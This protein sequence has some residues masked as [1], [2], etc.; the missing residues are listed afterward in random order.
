MRILKVLIAS[1]AF[2]ISCICSAQEL[3]VL[4][5]E[6]D[7]TDLTAQQRNRRDA[8]GNIC[9]LLRVLILDSGTK[10]AGELAYATE[11]LR[12]EY[13]VWLN[14]GAESIYIKTS[15]GRILSVDFSELGETKLMPGLVYLLRVDN[16]LH[17]DNVAK[18]NF[19]SLKV[20]PEDAV[21]KINGEKQDYRYGCVSLYLPYGSYEYEISK[22]G[23]ETVSGNFSVSTE[24]YTKH[25]R[26]TKAEG[27]IRLTCPEP[28]AEIWLDGK[29]V[30]IGT[31]SGN[32][33]AGNHKVKSF[34]NSKE[35]SEHILTIKSGDDKT[36]RIEAPHILVTTK[37]NFN[38]LP[39]NAVLSLD[40]AVTDVTEFSHLPL[41]NHYMDVK[42][43]GYKSLNVV[44]EAKRDTVQTIDL[45]LETGDGYIFDVF[46]SRFEMIPVKGG[47][48]VMGAFGPKGRQ[49]YYTGSEHPTVTLSDFSIG[50]YKVTQGLWKKL[51][52]NV[53]REEYSGDSI[54][55]FNRGEEMQRKVLY[56]DDNNLVYRISW[57]NINLFINKLN[58]L[59]G[60]SFRLPTEAE[61]EFAAKGGNKSQGYKYSGSD[62]DPFETET[63]IPNEL[64]IWG[65]TFCRFYEVTGDVYDRKRRRHLSDNA[66]NPHGEDPSLIKDAMVVVKGEDAV[67]RYR[68]EK[69]FS[70]NDFFYEG[71][72]L[73]TFRLVMEY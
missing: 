50:K 25:I 29:C 55:Y 37:I 33:L 54:G 69:L 52:F 8:T 65:M 30:G 19:A 20:Y 72:Q 42:M 17:E 63:M 40:G 2:L 34:K 47:T 66:V 31:W 56:F 22:P 14:S 13:W 62:T 46:G 7:E 16:P 5:F 73:D 6:K 44:F 21:V 70:P 58:K 23:Y 48:F 4:H 35:S 28:E 10:F 41:G 32:L 24:S 67:V 64:G 15:D 36:Y 26:L 68:T 1:F 38:N 39:A 53:G 27:A 11:P 61:W 43:P 49:R 45:A 59:T 9:P 3:R 12:N 60:H 18:G 51:G 57:E 71:Q